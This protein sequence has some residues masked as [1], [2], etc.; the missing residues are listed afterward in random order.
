MSDL[1]R[2]VADGWPVIMAAPWTF[3]AIMFA[4]V[5]VAVPCIWKAFG[6]IYQSRL[7]S[8]DG[9]IALLQ[10]QRDDYE[11]KLGG[12][13]PD[14]ASARIQ[15]LER[16]LLRMEPRR[17]TAEQCGAI[18]GALKSSIGEAHT[19]AVG[20][21]IPCPDCRIYGEE[22]CA[23]IQSVPGWTATLRLMLAPSVAS[24]KGAAILVPEPRN[25]NRTTILLMR[26]FVEAGIDFEVLGVPAEHAMAM[27]DVL[28]TPRVI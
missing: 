11:K 14:E 5:A 26:A 18:V 3:A 17:L 10:R 19:V 23:A 12:A 2:K 20:H 7:E 24:A 15:E 13:S 6:W 9:Q 25:P 22:I 16:R 28:V 1:Y 4:F 27:A 21:E 8:K